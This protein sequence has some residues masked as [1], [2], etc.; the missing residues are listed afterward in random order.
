MPALGG[1]GV[2]VFPVR[3]QWLV[4]LMVQELGAWGLGFRVFGSDCMGYIVNGRHKQLP[5]VRNWCDCGNVKPRRKT[6]S[7]NIKQRCPASSAPDFLNLSWI[8]KD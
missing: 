6:G 8:L 7:R 4:M 2:S 1:F 5:K 3:V